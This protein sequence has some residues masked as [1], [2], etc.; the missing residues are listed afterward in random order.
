VEV[1][2]TDAV[3]FSSVALLLAAIAFAAAAVPAIGATR[4][5]P[6]LALRSE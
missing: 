4:V 5:D 2:P 6:M 3:T 1:T